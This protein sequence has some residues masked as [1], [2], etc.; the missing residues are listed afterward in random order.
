MRQP[1]LILLLAV[2][3]LVGSVQAEEPDSN[4][5]PAEVASQEATGTSTTAELEQQL[6]A[7]TRQ[8]DDLASQLDGSLNEQENAQLLRLRQD[9]QKLQL[10]LREALSRQP[11]NL[12]G[13]TQVW[14][15]L[16]GITALLGAAIGA[17]LRGN[18]RRR[19]WLN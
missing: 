7:M 12:L 9:N 17:L 14:Y 13:E 2:L 8:R 19:E 18:R 5:Q 10:Q 11:Q 16:G 15:L 4:S 3:P 6:A 1:T